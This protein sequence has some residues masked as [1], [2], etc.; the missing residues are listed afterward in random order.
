MSEAPDGERE[1]S[2][3]I[4]LPWP[5]VGAGLLGFVVLVLMAGVFANRNL[6]PRVGV[7][8]TSA[9]SALATATPIPIHMRHPVVNSRATPRSDP[10]SRNSTSASAYSAI[11]GRTYSAPPPVRMTREYFSPPPRS[12]SARR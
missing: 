8:P 6:R 5:V 2:R 9:L 10:S 3:Y 11:S 7:V 1:P 12:R 4:R